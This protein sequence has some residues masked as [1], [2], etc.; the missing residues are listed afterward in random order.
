[1][2]RITPYIISA[3]IIA[4]L[5]GCAGRKV[6][7]ASTRMYHAFTARYTTYYNGSQAYN[8]A[9]KAQKTGHKDNYL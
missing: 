6:N 1:M 8:Q 9:L 3:L 2:R 5:C 7:N 4:S